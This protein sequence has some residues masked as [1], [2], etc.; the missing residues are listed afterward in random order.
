MPE[1]IENLLKWLKWNSSNFLSLFRFAGIFFTFFLAEWSVQKKLFVYVI[2]ETT[3]A[4]DG[5][6][7]RKLGNN[8]GF[9]MILDPVVDKMSKVFVLIFFFIHSLLE[10]YMIGAIILGESF[11]LVI[12][13]YG[14]YLSVKYHAQAMHI[15]NRKRSYRK[16]LLNAR[17]LVLEKWGVNLAGKIAMIFYAIMAALIFFNIQIF[18]N[19][20]VEFGYHLAFWGGFL[21][22][23]VSIPLYGYAVYEAQ[24]EL[25]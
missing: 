22:R 21:A 3:D 15:T 12:V 18:K 8:R 19:E 25:F 17:D 23:V 14:V 1:K 20:I 7:A 4:L 24:K 10:S 13:F 11:V 9:G 6:L 16:I 5:I 2:L